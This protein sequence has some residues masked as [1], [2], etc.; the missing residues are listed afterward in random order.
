MDRV[1]AVVAMSG[2]VDSSVAAALLKEKGYQVI[3]V[4]MQIW[5][6]DKQEYEGNGSAGCCGIG[7]IEDAK[8]VAHRLDIPHYVM[9]FRDIFARKVITDFCQEYSLG[10]TPNPCIRCNQYIKFGTLLER[11]R[12]L[13]ADIIATGHHARVEMDKTTETFLLKKGVDRHKDQS[14]F[15]YPVMQEQLKHIFFPI[16]NFTKDRIREMAS[17][18]RLPVAAKPESQ[19]ICFIPDHNYPRFLKDYNHRA[20]EPGPILDKRGNILGKHEG[21]LFYTIGQRKGLGIFAEKPLY[22]TAIEPERNAIVVGNKDELY[23][24]ELIASG[25]NWI[26]LARPTRPITVKAK[27][28]YRH[29]EAEAEVAPSDGDKAYVKFRKPQMAIT[30]GQA[31]VFYDND[32]VIGGGTIEQVRR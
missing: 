19:D 15:L 24:H 18:L 9:N 1:K 32:T 16:G 10:R 7:A 20:V 25:V 2:G 27:I 22:V 8:R 21:I 14:Y 23:G 30:P 26:T 17:E 29:Q 3:G 4:T 13:G 5:P 11:A 12:E 28:R 31:I 6:Q